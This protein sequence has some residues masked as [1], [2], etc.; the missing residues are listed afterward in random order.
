MRQGIEL[1]KLQIG[2]S[3]RLKGNLNFSSLRIGKASIYGI[4][5]SSIVL[6]YCHIVEME[7]LGFINK[8][9]LSL[10]SIYAHDE[11]NSK[12]TISKSLLGKTFISDCDLSKFNTVTITHSNLT[13]LTTTSVKW[14]NEDH[15]NVIIPAGLLSNSLPNTL[16]GNKGLIANTYSDKK[17]LYRQLKFV[18]EKQGDQVNRLV[19]KR[20]ELNCY[21][22]ELQQYGLNYRP[23]DRFI[24]WVSRSNDYGFNWAKPAGLI[25]L[26]SLVFYLLLAISI[27]PTLKLLPSWENTKPTISYL[28]NNLY[29]Y[30]TLLNP[31]HKVTDLFQIKTAADPSFWFYLE[32][33]L[34]RLII[35]YLIFQT[36][37][38]FRKYIS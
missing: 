2:C 19:F 23:G 24:L 31:A 12:I 28:T 3:N 13:E 30:F 27:N 20:K 11:P 14:F 38:A 9:A 8:G 10:I 29:N 15:L 35:S 17:E 33:F 36:I 26:F 22:K 34:D 16:T 18:M 21:R 6:A 32:D 7:L 1:E 37:T 25:F 5:E 4:N